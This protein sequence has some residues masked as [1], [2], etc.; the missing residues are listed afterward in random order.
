MKPIRT[1]TTGAS[2]LLALGAGSVQAAALAD[3]YQ[4]ALQNDP[5]LKSAQASS[6]ANQET[7]DQAKANLLPQ[8][9]LSADTRY[10]D[11]N[12]ADYNNH[13][14]T[15]TLSQ[16]VFDASRWYTF[17]Q[18]QQLSE[19]AKLQFEQAQQNLILR[20]VQAYLDVLRAQTALETAQAQER[21]IKRRLDQVNAQFEVGL[22]AITDVQEAQASYDNARVER[23][24]AEGALDNSFEALERLT[25]A[26]VGQVDMLHAD[27][28]VQNLAPAEPQPWLEK[29]WQGNF[30]LRI[31]TT[32]IEAQR[33]ALQAA[34]SGHYPTLSLDASYDD[35]NGNSGFTA[36]TENT[37]TSTIGLTLK[38]PLYAGGGTSSQVRQAE[39]QLTAIQQDREDTLR[40]VTQS[41]RSALRDLRTNVQSVAARK[42]SIKSSETALKAT[43]EGFNV[44]TRNVVDVLEAEQALYAAQR[45]YANA[46]YDYV[47]NLFQLKQQVGTLNPDDINSLDQWLVEP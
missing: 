40:A 3:I 18:G 32:A 7:A 14:Y 39:Y 33:R 46:R 26:A 45:D 28:P 43:E 35:D 31:A 25:G 4:Q 22:I 29:A 9:D 23:I 37:E 11:S 42:Q 30:D 2:L 1:L 5:Q 34:R 36:G 15:L 12:F 17:K 27:Y 38:V 6:L 24:E 13:G 21:A 16:P 19:Q 10:V 41:T 44:G 8:I 47:L 20:V